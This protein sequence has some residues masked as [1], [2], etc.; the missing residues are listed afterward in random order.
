MSDQPRTRQELYERVRQVGRETFIL[1]QMIRLGFWAKE[2][3]I[4]SDPADEIRRRDEVQLELNKLRT[5]NRKLY[6]EEALLKEL[7]KKRLAESRKR[8]QETKEHRERERIQRTEEWKR[9]KAKEIVYLGANVSGGLNKFESD[10]ERLNQNNLPRY[11]KPEEIA[12]AMNITVGKLRFLA[13][14]RKTST[15]SHYIHFKLPKKTGGERLINAPMPDLKRV[16]HWVLDNIL[17]RIAS[18]FLRTRFSHP[19]QHRHKC[20]EST[21]AQTLL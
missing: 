11:D 3:E 12:A 13:F 5:E 1:K 19:T 21:S 20:T 10:E 16:Q 17:N 14:D 7:R 4:P 9:K 8:K 2:G 15:F 6:N 18:H